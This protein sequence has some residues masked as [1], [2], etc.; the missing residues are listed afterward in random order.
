MKQ[1]KGFQLHELVCRHVY[2]RDGQDAWRYFAPVLLDFLTWFRVTIDKPVY[3]NNWAWK[4]GRTQRGL[5]CNLCPICKDKTKKNIVYLSGH[6]TGYAVDFE[7]KDMT[8]NEVR[9]WIDKNIHLF[10][11]KHPQYVAK[12]RI[13]SEEFAPTWCHIDFYPHNGPGIVQYIKPIP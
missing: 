4:G 12:I 10:F 2:N 5:R 11:K 7:V 13:E 1:A 9:A 6:V 3:V 8:P